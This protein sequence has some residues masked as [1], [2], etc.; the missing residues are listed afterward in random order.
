MC[1]EKRGR[2]LSDSLIQKEEEERGM[3]EEWS[4]M[5]EK[6]VRTLETKEGD[7]KVRVKWSEMRNVKL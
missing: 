5:K 4:S 2:R 6:I 7:M 3:D 1:T